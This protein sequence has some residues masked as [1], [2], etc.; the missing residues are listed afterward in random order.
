MMN[1]STAPVEYVT[2]AP[3]QSGPPRTPPPGHQ[4]YMS[5]GYEVTEYPDGSGSWWWKDPEIDSWKEWS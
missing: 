2:P 4:G 1:D 3:V 5:D